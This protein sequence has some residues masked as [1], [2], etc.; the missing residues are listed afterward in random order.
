[1]GRTRCPGPRRANA[2]GVWGNRDIGLCHRVGGRA[3][4]RHPAAA[5]DHLAALRPRPAV[6][7]C[8]FSHV[9][10]SVG[11]Y[12]APDEPPPLRGPDRLPGPLVEGQPAAAE[13]LPLAQGR[14]GPV[15]PRTA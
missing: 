4:A 5:L 11:Q 8:H 2:V 1:M 14:V 6:G 10:P 7:E 13:P 9:E 15:G 12:D 3:R